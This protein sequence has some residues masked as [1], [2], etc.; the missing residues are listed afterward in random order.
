[1]GAAHTS[2]K[3]TQKSEKQK[4]THC[5]SLLPTYPARTIV[6]PESRSPSSTPR[7]AG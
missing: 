5:E 4:S 7:P 1:M 6:L 2:A 3:V